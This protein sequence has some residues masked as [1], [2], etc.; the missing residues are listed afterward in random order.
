MSVSKG[1][2][3][4]IRVGTCCGLIA[5]CATMSAATLEELR[6]RA[7]ALVAQMTLDEK[8]AQLR[9]A[10]PAIPRLGI[11]AYDYWGEALH[12]VGR[13][14]RAT[15]F[16][17]PIGMAASFDTALVREVA[18][19]IAD[20]GR[21]KYRA[22]I[23]AGRGGQMNTGLNFW[24]P[25]VN[26]FRDPRWGRGIET[27]GED[28]YLTSRMGVAFI[29][30]IQGDDTVYLKAAAC[31]KH[32]AVHSGPEPERHTF[33]ARPSRKDLR[34]T[35]LPA[36][37]ACVR[38]GRVEAVMGAYNR[39]YGESA[40]ASTLLLKDILRGE[41]G[42]V[43]HVVS[44]CGAICDIWKSHKI[45][46]TPPEAVA[47]AIRNGLTVECGPCFQHLKKAIELGLV[48]EKEI[49]PLVARMLLCRL[50]LGI[51]GDDPACPYNQ[52]DPA[53]LSSDKHHALARQM[54]RE[55]M[56]L[57]KNDGV[58]PLNPN[59]G[60]YSVSG[61]GASDVFPLLGNY[62]GVSAR[63]STY[64][65]GLVGAVGP[66]VCVSYSPGYFYGGTKS[67]A[68]P[69]PRTED[70]S[71]VV[72]GL[73]G[74]FEG[75][76]GADVQLAEGFG[77]GDRTDLKLPANQMDHLRK[78]AKDRAKGKKVVVVLTGGSPVELAEIESLA[79][80]VVM[81]WYAGEAGGEALADLLF[82]KADFTGRLPVTFPTSA[83]ALPPFRDYAMVGRTYRYKTNGVAR[84]FGFGLS[85]AKM[86][87][88]VTNT[89]ADKAANAG[90]RVQVAVRNV[91]TRDGTAVVQLYVSTPNAGKGAPLKSLVGFR[92]VRVKVGETK[93]ETF[94]VKASQL[95]EYGEDGVPRRVP[96]M[97]TY[98][99]QL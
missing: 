96:G 88:R 9:N 33:D 48:T 67:T 22:T 92:R 15:V 55:S 99:V 63:M 62:Y 61:A 52:T 23:A 11:P 12:G 75:E 66:G 72:L 14:G 83:D 93:T 89:A 8:C 39:V 32:Y 70:I 34:E 30:G 25:N 82:G 36:F 74:A 59:R 40:S 97:C 1:E 64:L 65:E 4:L 71:I 7:D 26:I 87:A 54:A 24:S 35:Y 85:Y 77:R 69:W 3:G 13:N 20:E 2:K 58:L 53:C 47:L 50:R 21:V 45:V 95:M 19:A 51:L 60:F 57:L 86:T 46:E 79:D 27:W 41:W 80:A 98:S 38:E 68:S 29:R 43:G 81:A 56:V 84:A 73:N 76:E 42:F 91:G 31:A 16:P 49:D 37:E 28:P 44:D 94:E 5:V 18:S 10:A 17:E 90:E 6:A 78:V